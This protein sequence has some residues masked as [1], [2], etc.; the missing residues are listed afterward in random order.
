MVGSRI[1]VTDRLE[2]RPMVADDLDALHPILSDAAGWWYDPAGRHRDVDTTR[3]FIERAAAR[4]ERDGLS[5]WTVRHG[6]LGT[7]IGLGGAQR[8]A[9]GS[10]NLSYR[11]ATSKWG[12]GYAG[13]LG[14]A[15]LA[16]AGEHD[17]SVPCIAWVGPH[18]L[19]SRR[20]AERL[21]LTNY[22]LRK[23]GNDGH[24][25]LAYADRPLDA[26]PDPM[27]ATG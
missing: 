19:S 2:L 1:V 22:G 26:A 12:C 9:S 16:A 23:D 10:W 3:W 25:R 18:N 13:E 6:A 8:H 4:W 7:V 24:M 27:A 15:A 5:Y 20:V 21:G 11:I 17:P 14:R